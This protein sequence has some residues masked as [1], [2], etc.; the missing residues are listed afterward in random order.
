MVRGL[1][2]DETRAYWNH[3]AANWAWDYESVHA[4]EEQKVEAYLKAKGV[5]K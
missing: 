4:T 5:W 1:D 3:L 2:G